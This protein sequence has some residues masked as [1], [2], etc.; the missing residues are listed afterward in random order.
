MVKKINEIGADMKIIRP[1]TDKELN[2]AQVIII[3]E[4]EAI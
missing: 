3:N 2:T 1:L 4:N